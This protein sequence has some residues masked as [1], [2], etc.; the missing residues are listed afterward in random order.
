MFKTAARII[1]K[2]I[3]EMA[4][5]NEVSDPYVS[6]DATVVQMRA[7]LEAA[8]SDLVRCFPWTHLQTEHLIT[9]VVGQAEYDLPADFARTI[10][11]T[12]WDRSA[13]FPLSG[14]VDAVG[15]QT[16]KALVV[17]GG[18]TYFWRQVGTKVRVHPTPAAVATLALEYISAYWVQPAAES[19]RTAEEPTASTDVLHFDPYL[20]SRKLKLLWL[21]AKGFPSDAAR[22][23]YER[24]L[25]NAMGADGASPTLSLSRGLVTPGRLMDEHNIPETGLGM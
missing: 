13:S 3:T 5:G 1:N 24:A 4:L 25:D 12:A 11:G 10:N 18:V 7:L 14:P 8:G 17:V 16:L 19:T 21:E 6:T 2:S 20:L 15:W 22:A 9:T 23:D